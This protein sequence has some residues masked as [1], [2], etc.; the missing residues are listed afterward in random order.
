[1]QG[2]QMGGYP[3]A[4]PGMMPQQQMAGQMPQQQ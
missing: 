1:M 2:Q 4:P 3:Q